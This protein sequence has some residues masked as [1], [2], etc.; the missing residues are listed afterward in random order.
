MKRTLFILALTSLSMLTNAQFFRM[1]L[2]GGISS[3][4]VKFSKTTI[5]NGANQYIVEQGDSKLGFHAGLFARVQI[6][7][8]FVQPELLFS[9]SQGEVML[10]DVTLSN[11][12]NEMQK[13]N[14]FDIP[15]IVGWKFGP[16]RV[17]L[18]PVATILVSENDG[19]KDKLADL[20][21]QTVKNNF[22]LATF[23]YQVGVGLDMLKTLTLD[24]KYEGNFSKLGTGITLGDTNYSFD[25]RNP[26]IIMSVGFF[27]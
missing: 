4:N 14:K 20:T 15:V 9:R 17:G 10:K 27:F 25:Q 26:Q 5:T 11:A 18:G 24:L 3:S 16:A 12:Y 23:G 6:M 19:L 13:F 21:N 7:G 22:R 8:F 1:G 2:K